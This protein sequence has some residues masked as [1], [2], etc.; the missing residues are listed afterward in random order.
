MNMKRSFILFVL[1][2]LLG[3][4]KHP[5]PR[6]I[7]IL[8]DV[9]GS[10]ERRSL[11]QA[12]RAIEKLAGRLRRGDGLTIIPILGDAEAEASGRIIRVEVP[13]QRRA[14]DAD[15]HAFQAK[16]STT[17][18]SAESEALARPELRTDILGSVVLAEQEFGSDQRE[19]RRLLFVL[20]DFIQEGQDI[21]FK[22]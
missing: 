5:E 1:V 6:Q 8:V 12:S 2:A 9:S 17:L 22:T 13:L 20:S 18:K 11:E 4:G 21:D 3:C 15:I 7:V 16:L 19:R 10:I 14:Y